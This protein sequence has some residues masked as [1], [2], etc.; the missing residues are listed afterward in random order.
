MSSKLIAEIAVLGLSAAAVGALGQK[1]STRSRNRNLHT[2]RAKVRK[3]FKD[4]QQSIEHGQR[5]IAKASKANTKKFKVVLGGIVVGR[6]PSLPSAKFIKQVLKTLDQSL[7]TVDKA[8][9]LLNDKEA[10]QY[11]T[12]LDRAEAVGGKL[13]K[14]LEKDFIVNGKSILAWVKKKARQEMKELDGGKVTTVEKKRLEKQKPLGAITP[15]QEAIIT[16]ESVRKE[17]NRKKGG[18]K[19]SADLRPLS[20]DESDKF[21][22]LWN[23][24]LFQT[25][26]DVI[27]AWNRFVK[28]RHDK[29]RFV[30]WACRPI[31]DN[32]NPG[33]AVDLDSISQFRDLAKQLGVYPFTR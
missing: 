15:T 6:I 18:Q 2:A 3:A 25:G 30:V 23:K 9:I 28:S 5:L 11:S 8:V 22:K 7:N 10:A 32:G 31:A 29:Q 17:V 20:S 16:I 21:T 13:E 24:A 1:A 14:L 4:L 12:M 33:A 26:G 27:S 19:N